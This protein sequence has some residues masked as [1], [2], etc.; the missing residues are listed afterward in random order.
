[1]KFTLG[2][3]YPNPYNPVTTISYSLPKA[4]FVKLKIYNLSGQEILTL[5]E[6]NQP[7]G[8]Y[9]V[10]FDASQFARGMYI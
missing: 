9:Q 4:Q 7:A 8:N 10:K 1:V 6:E 3:N 5:V 2:Q